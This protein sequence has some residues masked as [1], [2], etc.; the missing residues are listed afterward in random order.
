MIG[1][2]DGNA[3]AHIVG[4]HDDGDAFG[5]FGGI[6]PLR[7]GNQVPL[8][9]AARRKVVAADAALAELRIA[10]R[11]TRDDQIRSHAPAVE[12]DGVVKPGPEY[13]RGAAR[14]LRRTEYYDGVGWL[15]LIAAGLGDDFE[16]DEQIVAGDRRQDDP[17]GPQPPPAKA[18]CGCERDCGAVRRLPP[19]S[20]VSEDLLNFLG[21]DGSLAHEL[22]AAPGVEQANDRRQRR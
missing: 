14:I 7:F 5:G 19:R 10:S 21:R 1:V 22:P 8:A 6:L 3:G 11:S 4:T 9:D 2:A 18:L 20:L 12:R 13:R 17:N 16:T 15:R